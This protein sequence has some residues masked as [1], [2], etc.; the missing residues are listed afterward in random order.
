MKKNGMKIKDSITVVD[1]IAAINDIVDACFYNGDYKPYYFDIEERQS[2]VKYFITGVEFEDGDYIY[3]CIENDKDL[4]KLVLKF[5][6]DISGTQKAQT[7][8]KRNKK[9]IDILNIVASNAIDIVNFRKE[10]MIH[11]T[12]DIKKINENIDYTTKAIDS[13]VVGVIDLVSGIYS[14]IENFAKLDLGNLTPEVVAN[15]NKFIKEFVESGNGD[16]NK[17]ITEITSKLSSK[18]PE[19]DFYEE[20]RKEIIRLKDILREHHIG[21]LEGDVNEIESDSAGMSSKNE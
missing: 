15:T 7:E 11:G 10:K 9:Y 5:Y 8:N 20:Q 14:V 19:T 4:K 16:V 3:D 1:Q 6:E 18:V 21:F 2:I 17:I 13:A 12:D